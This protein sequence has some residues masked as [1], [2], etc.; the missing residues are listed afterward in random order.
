MEIY[1]GKFL[2]ATKIILTGRSYYMYFNSEEAL[3]NYY[4][5]MR[6]ERGKNDILEYVGK[7]YF[8]SRGRLVEDDEHAIRIYDPYDEGSGAA[9]DYDEC[10][11]RYT[12]GRNPA[13]I[14]IFRHPQ[15]I[16]AH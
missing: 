1:Y 10:C 9:D 7:A 3:Y 8:N 2:E 15:R 4:R 6:E 11:L 13:Y 5:Y 14:S 16:S 12:L